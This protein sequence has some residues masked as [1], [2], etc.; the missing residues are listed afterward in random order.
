LGD[1]KKIFDVRTSKKVPFLAG[2]VDP[3]ACITALPGNVAGT[4]RGISE[5]L[6]SGRLAL[7]QFGTAV[8]GT[9]EFSDLDGE[10]FSATISGTVVGRAVTLMVE[11]QNTQDVVPFTF[12]GRLLTR[13]VM[14]GTVTGDGFS[15]SASLFKER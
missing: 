2:N 11:P 4:W 10:S 3:L 12:S 1:P 7:S 14:N 15:E 6:G 8:F 5:Q 13:N 9:G